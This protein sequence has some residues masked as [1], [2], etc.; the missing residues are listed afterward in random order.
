VVSV[1]VHSGRWSG[2]PRRLAAGTAL[3]RITLLSGIV[4]PGQVLVSH[5]AAAL[6]EGDRSVPT[7]R[8]LGRRAIPGL[9]EPAH[10]YELPDSPEA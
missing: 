8:D 5:T 7:L 4:E 9:D 2:D 1:A 10:L 3:R 6:V